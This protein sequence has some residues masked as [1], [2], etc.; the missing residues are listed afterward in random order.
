MKNEKLKM[1][2]VSVCESQ[3]FFISNSSF[4]IFHLT[5]R[6]WLFILGSGW[7]SHDGAAGE[8]AD[9]ARDVDVAGLHDHGDFAWRCAGNGS[10]G[11]EHSGD[12]GLH[13]FRIMNGLAIVP[14]QLDSEDLEQGR[15]LAIPRHH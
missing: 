3:S 15:V 5:G 13:R 12:I 6:E 14:A 10:S 8:S 4:F 1:Q 2:N 7:E 11:Y 9:D